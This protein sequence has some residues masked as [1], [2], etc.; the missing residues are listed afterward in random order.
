M[1]SETEI[2][3]IVYRSFPLHVYTETKRTSDSLVFYV[4]GGHCFAFADI[5]LIAEEGNMVYIP[6]GSSYT[7]Y[8]LSDDTEYFQVD[9]LTFRNG[10]ANALFDAPRKFETYRRGHGVSLWRKEGT[11]GR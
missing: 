2:K 3:R 8:T 1:K 11:P 4:K 10:I 7:N 6:Y 9:F 5:S